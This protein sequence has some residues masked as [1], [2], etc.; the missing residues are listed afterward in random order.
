MTARTASTR[1]RTRS[2]VVEDIVRW[3]WWREERS[4]RSRSLC[5][6]EGWAILTLTEFEGDKDVEVWALYVDVMVKTERGER[7]AR[8][9]G[10][11]RGG[12][13]VRI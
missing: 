13:V 4:L 8:Y 6:E 9:S 10:W 12:M 11:R 7:V 3:W 1:E 5:E 2:R